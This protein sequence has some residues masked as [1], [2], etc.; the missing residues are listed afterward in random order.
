MC[1]ISQ[2]CNGLLQLPP[3][4]STD[5]QPVRKMKVPC[6]RMERTKEVAMGKKTVGVDDEY[7]ALSFGIPI[8]R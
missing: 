8:F 2:K 3:T 6:N 4:E 7:F 5:C 1:R